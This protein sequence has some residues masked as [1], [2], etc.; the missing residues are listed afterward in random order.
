NLQEKIFIKQRQI[1]AKKRRER[2]LTSTIE[3]YSRRI[4]V[5]Q[6]DITTLQE[7]QIEIETDLA[8][9]RA[10]LDR[11]QDDLRSERARITRLRAR[12]AESRAAL[13]ARLV[14][15]FKADEP[16]MVTVV[17]ESNGFEDLLQRTEFMQRVSRPD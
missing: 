2:S 10:E 17:L 4:G 7:R 13:S 12:L 8:N 11:I 6:G 1:E 14:H 16:D 9:K 3:S 5:L 15:L